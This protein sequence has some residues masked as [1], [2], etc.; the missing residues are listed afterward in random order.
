MASSTGMKNKT[1]TAGAFSVALGILANVI[2][3]L[4]ADIVLLERYAFLL[5]L[6]GG[7]IIG[8]IISILIVYYRNGNFEEL[9][10]DFNWRD[11][12]INE[13]LFVLLFIL[14]M[15]GG[16]LYILISFATFVEDSLSTIYSEIFEQPP[17]SPIIEFFSEGYIWLLIIF[18][19]LLWATKDP[20]KPFVPKKLKIFIYSCGIVG[21]SAIFLYRDI[22]LVPYLGDYTPL[23]WIIT[24]ILV[25]SVLM[26]ELESKWEIL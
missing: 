11:Y 3:N 19:I 24:A 25:L 12:V 20:R 9:N 2:H 23:F 26:V 4:I 10:S 8:S 22:V 14:I 6:L 21:I 18:V 7:L 1:K 17:P 16:T 5:S 13:N 15:A